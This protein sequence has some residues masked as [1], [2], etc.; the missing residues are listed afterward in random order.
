MSRGNPAFF[1]FDAAS[2]T[3]VPEF[4]FTPP[5][6]DC[7]CPSRMAKSMNYYGSILDYDKVLHGG[8]IRDM[9]PV[10]TSCGLCR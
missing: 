5:E 7:F 6:T 1:V 4:T 2:G 8:S 3:S 10:S 9:I